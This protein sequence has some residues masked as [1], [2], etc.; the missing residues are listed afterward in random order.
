[1]TDARSPVLLVAPNWLGDLV[2]AAPLLEAFA[3][4]ADDRGVP[5]PLVSVRRRWADLLAGD[6]RVRRLHRYHRSGRHAGPAGTWRLAREWAELGAEAALLLPPSLRAAVAARLAG[7]PRRIGFRGEGRSCLLTDPVP[8]PPRGSLHYTAE[9]LRL[10]GVWAA[11]LPG[12]PPAALPLTPPWLPAIETWRPAAAWRDGPPWWVLGVGATYGGA[13]VWPAARAAE[14]TAALVAEGRR[15]VLLGDAAARGQAAAIR[16]LAGVPGGRGVWRGRPGVADLTGATTLREAVAL[17]NGAETFVGNDSGLMHVAAAAGTPTVGLFGSSNPAWTGPR[18]PFAVA[19]TPD[20]YP[21]HPC[22]RR[23]CPRP[24]FCL[25]TITADRVLAAAAR[26][27]E[28]AT[29][30]GRL[31][32]RPAEPDSPRPTLLLD[33]DGVLVDDPGYLSDPG[34]LRLLPGVTAALRRAVRAGLRLVVVTNQSGIGRGYLSRP[35]S[36]AIQSRLAWR[37]ALAGASLAAVYYCPHAPADGCACRKP[38]P[39]LV[40]AARRDFPWSRGCAWLVGDKGSDV[41]LGR[42]CGLRTLLVRT[43]EG[44]RT[45][46]ALER[47]DDV[48]VVDDLAAAVAV[49]LREAGT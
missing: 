32:L 23:R 43:G 24:D 10:W 11:A 18:G 20:G 26:L 21:C 14:L 42:R 16:G 13:K 35:R 27:R 25:E 44:R 33:R 1:M 31:L 5:L 37:L 6:P 7:V 3:A 34:A 47:R 48:T 39:G 12:D 15:V 30:P 4:A 36:E 29:G 9:Q 41:A 40:E 22:Y 17:I 28:S 49:V 46:A 8:R 19:L 2:M 38:E 45:E